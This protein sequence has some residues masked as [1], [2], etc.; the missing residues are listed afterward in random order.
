MTP[1][2]AQQIYTEIH[3]THL[4]RP[5]GPRVKSP[6]FPHHH[7]H[8][9]MTA[10]PAGQLC[11][12]PLVST[13]RQ[14]RRRSLPS[15]ASGA[16]EHCARRRYAPATV[17]VLDGASTVG[18]GEDE[19]WCVDVKSASNIYVKTGAWPKAS[20]PSSTAPRP[21]FWPSACILM[22]MVAD[23]RAQHPYQHPPPASS[24]ASPATLFP[25]A[26][27]SRSTSMSRKKFDTGRRPSPQ[28]D[29]SINLQARSCTS[30]LAPGCST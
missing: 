21:A 16:R 18:V 24:P 29:A 22:R 4:A 8:D 15:S 9:M 26:S 19:R 30:I 13:R 2:L 25:S 12:V 27:S 1:P 28:R 6:S 5:S 7:H 10:D 20:P 14:P 3:K 23:G 17:V 11:Y